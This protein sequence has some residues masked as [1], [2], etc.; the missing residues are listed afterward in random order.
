[1]AKYARGRYRSPGRKKSTGEWLIGRTWK[2]N[3][4]DPNSKAGSG[5][6]RK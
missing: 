2:K 1:M 3:V 5:K 4:G 6:S